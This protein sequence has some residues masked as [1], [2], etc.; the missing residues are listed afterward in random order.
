MP[1]D[2]DVRALI[3]A[4]DDQGFQSF[5]KLGVEGTR[6]AVASFTGLQ[7]PKRGSCRSTDVSYGPDPAHRARIHVPPGDR[8]L[9]VVV[10]VHGGGFVAGNLDVVDERARALAVD[11][12]AIVVSVTYRLAPEARF[13]AAH[14]D[15]FAALRWTAKEISAHGGDPDRIAVMGDSA[16][17]TLAAA[18]V[19]RARDEGEPPVRAQVLVYP[20]VDPLADTASRRE[21]AEGYLLHLD[22]LQWFGAQYVSGPEDV[23]DPRLALGR[24]DL[25]GLP[26]TLV[27]TTEYDTLRDEGE[28]FAAALENAGVR[29]A[30]RRMDGLVHA[31]YW[32]SAAIPRSAEIHEAAVA[33]LRRNL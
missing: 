28:A 6:A 7:L 8:P 24:N 30:H 16:G 11:T 29:A 19:I 17:G 22:A 25:A 12:G 33:H 20:L 14:D 31:A 27:V 1:L 15:V 5:E 21:F 3:G 10:Y 32:A 23:T 18:A 4:L 2:P 13:P 26:P 9:P